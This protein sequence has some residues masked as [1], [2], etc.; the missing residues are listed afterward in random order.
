M[1]RTA[2]VI[3]NYEMMSMN[4]NKWT[5]ALN[6]VIEAFLMNQ[7]ETILLRV[8]SQLSHS[9]IDRQMNSYSAI[10]DQRVDLCPELDSAGGR[11]G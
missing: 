6:T 10:D 4:G 2:T 5:T 8:A 3:Q 7:F 1:L 9:L 11:V